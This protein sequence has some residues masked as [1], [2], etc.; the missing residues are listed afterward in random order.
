MTYETYWSLLDTSAKSIR[1]YDVF[2]YIIVISFIAWLV[3][4]KFKKSNGDIEKLILLWFAGIVFAISLS[5]FI[6]LKLYDNDESYENTRKFLESSQVERVEGI[7]TNFNSGPIASRRGVTQESFLVD[8]IYFY[9]SDELLGRFNQ[10]GK[11][12]NGV[13]KNGLQVRITYGGNRHQ[14]YKIEIAK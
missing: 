5:G 9:Y 2:L 11:T 6:Y 3:T 14:I 12:N 4:K 8:S 13:L 10:F 7:I 1:S